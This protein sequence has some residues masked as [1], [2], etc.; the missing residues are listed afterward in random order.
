MVIL[1][2]ILAI[3]MIFVFRQVLSSSP[4]K[5]KG[6]TE[7]ETLVATGAKSGQDINWQIPDPLPATMRDPIKLPDQGSTSGAEPNETAVE[8]K[9]GD[10]DVRDIIFSKVK[11]SAFVN[12]RI[13]Y[14]GDKILN[15]TVVQ[16]N[17]D[18]VEFE[19]DGKMWTQNIRD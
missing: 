18:S 7:D 19:R 17:R 5:T 3:V 15:A 8:P 12:G 11:P 13:V 16:I 1:V 14:I 9:A 2:P 6:A 4:R 10:L